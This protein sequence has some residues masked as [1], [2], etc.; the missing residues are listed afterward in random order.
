[1]PLVKDNEEL[2][3]AVCVDIKFNPPPDI[4]AGKAVIA[5]KELLLQKLRDIV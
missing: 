1:M 3:L 2:L 5:D 4:E